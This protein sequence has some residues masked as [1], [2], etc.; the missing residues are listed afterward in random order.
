VSYTRGIQKRRVKLLIRGLQATNVVFPVSETVPEHVGIDG[1]VNL[2][3]HFDN[4]DI[5]LRRIADDSSI[6]DPSIGIL[7]H[8]DA[9]RAVN[10]QLEPT[11]S[12]SQQKHPSQN[13]PQDNNIQNLIP[14]TLTPPPPTLHTLPLQNLQLRLQPR[15]LALQ[16]LALDLNIIRALRDSELLRVQRQDLARV[17]A[18]VVPV[19]FVLVLGVQ[20]V[21]AAREGFEGVLLR[22]QARGAVGA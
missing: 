8:I 22:G 16:P 20:V 17:L 7:R 14:L 4:I 11:E 6:E 1:F 3:V 15:Q 19:F 13:K 21:E 9:E 10:L 12:Q 18:G 2:A 5:S